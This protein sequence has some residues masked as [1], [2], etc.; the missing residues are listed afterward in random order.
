[1]PKQQNNRKLTL[2]IKLPNKKDSGKKAK[3]RFI[4]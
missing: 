3:T 1:M 2:T 4:N